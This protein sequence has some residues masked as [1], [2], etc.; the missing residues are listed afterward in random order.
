MA[1]GESYLIKGGR[2]MN[3]SAT[4]AEDISIDA[5]LRIDSG[6]VTEVK[7]KLRTHSDELE[8]D[9]SG[10]WIL[11]GFI[12]LHTH[13][14]DLGQADRETIESGTRAAAAGGY[15]TVVAMA[16]TEPPTDNALVLGRIRELINRHACIQVLPVACVTKGMNGIELTNMVELAEMG[17]I[18]FSDDGMPL[19]DLAVLRRALEYAELTGRFIISHPE[20]RA[21][22][23]GGAMNEGAAAI[24]LG[25]PG[26]PSVS[27]SACVAREIEVV[28]YTGGRLHFAHVS[29]ALSVEL[30]RR[31][32]ADR[33][34]I[35]ADV[36]PHHL[37]LCDEDIVDF[38]SSYK[39]NPPLR[40]R[41]DQAALI[42]G[43]SD[44]TI[45][46][47]ATDH[48]PHTQFEKAKSF[49][50]APFGIIGLETA[51][52][53]ALERLSTDHPISQLE[54]ISLFTSNPAR[55]LGL[56]EPRIEPGMPANLSL[57]DPKL[58]WKYDSSTGCSKSRN[59]P[60]HGR[61]LTGKTLFTFY[62]GEVVYQDET[63]THGRFT[64]QT[65]SV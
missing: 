20:D 16:N 15:T 39:M 17:A 4:V 62:N 41:K 65:L 3:P 32:K 30:I 18:A 42:Q 29:T 36:T 35:S 5:D 1:S 23:C 2:I 63:H 44:G 40:T 43:L 46:A 49:D 26:I 52:P 24:R 56:G 38:D 10:L 47:I 48:A 59:S 64:K 31:A 57:F 6:A 33:L 50:E 53:L 37:V 25:L 60:F 28:R 11:P 55:V 45:D 19:S 58:R 14:R 21:L 27:E 54:T 61:R 9:A 22:A 51:F 34:R 12:D 7:P 8:I 13:L